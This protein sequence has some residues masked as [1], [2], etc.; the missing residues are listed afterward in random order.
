MT[1]KT[2][3]RSRCAFTLIELLVVIAIIAILAAMLLPTL[4]RAKVQA[5]SAKCKS[6]LHQIGLALHLY[7]TDNNS[8]YPFFTTIA[9]MSQVGNAGG[10]E[11]SCWEMCLQTYLGG[12]AI[13]TSLWRGGQVISDVALLYTNCAVFRCPGYKGVTGGPFVFEEGHAGSYGYNAVGIS[14]APGLP[15]NLG[16]GWFAAIDGGYGPPGNFG[17]ATTTSAVQAPADMIAVCESRVVG[18]P[19]QSGTLWTT[20]DFIVPGS[21]PWGLSLDPERHGRNYNMVFCDGHVEG[22]NPAIVF[23]LT[24]SAARWNKDHQPHPEMWQ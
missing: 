8:K 7:T 15:Q 22:L 21:N 23:N 3:Q 19:N 17:P 12:P 9:A 24:N 20:F 11:V 10:Q 18:I 5:Q 16:L 13:P 14:F 4:A 6:N 2:R 1:S